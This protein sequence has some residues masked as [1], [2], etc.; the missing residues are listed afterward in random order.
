MTMQLSEKI[1]LVTGGTGELGRVI[2]Q[3]FLVE[4][5]TVV[6]TSRS[7]PAVDQEAPGSVRRAR[8]VSADLSNE[9]DV[10]RLYDDAR[11]SFGR[12]DIVV[13]AVG[14]FLPRKPLTEV[15]AAEWDSMMTINLR[16]TFLSTREALRLM[17][18][19][20]YGRIINISAMV[21]LQPGPG[22]APYAISK[23]GVSMLTE[24]VAQELK[25]SGITINAIAPGIIAT[26]SN[27]NSMPDED[28]T[29][30]V[31]PEEIADMICYLCS[32]A[33]GAVNGT[34]LKAYGAL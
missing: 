22:R 16:T 14:G 28:T 13:N 18:G 5:A 8:I 15:S 27:I 20:F 12:L 19:Q 3:R 31:K 6:A 2:V 1:A 25:G 33:G 9:A 11:S 29:K 7:V 21:G 10:V 30:W 17:K 26:K 24:I 23:A 32:S 4:G 34:T